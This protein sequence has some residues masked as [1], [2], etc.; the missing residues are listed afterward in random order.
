MNSL[1][2]EEFAKMQE[3]AIEH[4]KL[5][6]SRAAI[7]EKES[8][9]NTDNQGHKKFSSDISKEEKSQNKDFSQKPSAEPFSRDF[10]FAPTNKN[11]QKDDSVLLAFLLILIFDK[12]DKILIFALIYIM[13]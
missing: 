8:T 7:S 4:A 6:K 3:S 11:N 9:Q 2:D 12:A 5:M 1:S 10:K 13:L